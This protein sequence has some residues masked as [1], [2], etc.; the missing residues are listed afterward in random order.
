MSTARAAV[1]TTRSAAAAVFM[2]ALSAAAIF[3]RKP[4]RALSLARYVSVCVY[5]HGDRKLPA[6]C[7]YIVFLF[8]TLK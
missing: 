2:L 7:V 6:Q 5:I 4:N 3:K 1:C 8:P